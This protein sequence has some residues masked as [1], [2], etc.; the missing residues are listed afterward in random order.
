ME[1]LLELFWSAPSNEFQE[2]YT[3]LDVEFLT[4]K[5]GGISIFDAKRRCLN[6][7]IDASLPTFVSNYGLCCIYLSD[8]DDNEIEFELEENQFIDFIVYAI[9]SKLNADDIY[10]ILRD[11]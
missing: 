11:K 8:E 5:R 4:N 10:E 7:W 9:E 3:K 6:C 2:E 1:K